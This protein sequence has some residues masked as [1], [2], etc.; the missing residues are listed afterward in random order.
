MWLKARSGVLPEFNP[1]VDL[2]RTIMSAMGA[3]VP[4]SLL[5]AIAFLNGALLV[6]FV[7]HRTYDFLPGKSSI[8]KGVAFGVLAWVAMG[9]VLFPLIGEGLF[10]SAVGR[11]FLPALL[12]LAMLLIYG[13]TLSV[14]YSNLG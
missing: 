10:A 14:I 4:Q 13:L 12:S 5:W 1:Y 8:T 3:L 9:L 11:G 6:S 2:Q 7:F